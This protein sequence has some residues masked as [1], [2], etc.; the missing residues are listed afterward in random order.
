MK[1]NFTVLIL[2]I[3]VRIA[4]PAHAEV[5]YDYLPDDVKQKLDTVIPSVRWRK[6]SPAQALA[7]I[8][9]KVNAA[10]PSLVTLKLSAPGAYPVGLWESNTAEP[11]RLGGNLAA[12][13]ILPEG[14]V[15]ASVR[16][17][18]ARELIDYICGEC[19]LDIADFGNGVVNLVPLKLRT[20]DVSAIVEI[21]QCVRTARDHFG[22]DSWLGDI[23]WK[24]GLFLQSDASLSLRPQW[25]KND[26][27]L[28]L[29][30]P[31]EDVWKVRHLIR[32]EIVNDRTQQ[33]P[34]TADERTFW[35][36][37]RSIPKT[38]I[39]LPSLEL[40]LGEFVQKLNEEAGKKNVELKIHVPPKLENALPTKTVLPPG[41]VRADDPYLE[42]RPDSNPEGDLAF[43]LRLVLLSYGLELAARNNAE[44]TIVPRGLCDDWA[45]PGEMPVWEFKVSPNL[46]RFMASKHENRTLF[47]AEEMGNP[48]GSIVIYSKAT[49]TLTVKNTW[50]NLCSIRYLLDTANLEMTA[51]KKRPE[52]P[53]R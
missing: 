34:M 12:G 13:G 26:T 22:R 36:L 43:G 48:P 41:M 1:A 50:W 5:G 21:P 35:Q 8:V 24:R 51:Q 16:D 2:A 6:V 4:S 44:F 32:K 18:T 29:D 15:Y 42:E 37:F 46:L 30:G 9:E 40:P 10:A 27:V 49:L 3:V 52:T 7:D 14:V 28:R 11:V 25:S 53:R 47:S 31:P 17:K 33:R 19:A 45:D 38:P 39:V 23:G 20:S